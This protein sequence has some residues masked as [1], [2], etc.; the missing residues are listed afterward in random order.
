[1]DANLALSIF[2][3]PAKDVITVYSPDSEV[4]MTQILDINGKLVAKSEETNPASVNLKGIS[5]GVYIMVVKTESGWTRHKI[6]V[7]HE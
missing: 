2:P 3:N 6:I 1:M 5:K 4:E 7:N